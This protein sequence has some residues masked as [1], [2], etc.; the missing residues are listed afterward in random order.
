MNEKR[1][2]D[3]TRYTCLQEQEV[4]TLT[5]ALKLFFRET[6]DLIPEKVLKNISKEPDAQCIQNIRQELM[7]LD[8]I[9]RSTLK[10]LIKHLQT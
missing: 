3:S 10:Y 5:S 1:S 6:T 7:T 9:Y 2:K 4:H 8:L